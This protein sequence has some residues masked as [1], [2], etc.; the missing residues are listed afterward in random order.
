VNST[1]SII[2]KPIAALDRGDTF[3][4][5]SWVCVDDGAG[6]FQLHL[7]MTPNPETGLVTLSEVITGTLAKQFGE[8]SL[9]N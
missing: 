8:I 4:F 3:V 6:S 5:S 1:A 7:T 9:Y 2:I